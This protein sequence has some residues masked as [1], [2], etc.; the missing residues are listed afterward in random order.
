MAP[1]DKCP[2]AASVVSTRIALQQT[3]HVRV[4]ARTDISVERR[5]QSHHCRLRLFS[6][7][8]NGHSD[9]VI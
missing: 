1:T 8:R 7:D 9:N 3:R 4:V 5:S 6:I 2:S